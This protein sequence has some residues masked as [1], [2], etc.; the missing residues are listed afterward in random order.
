MFERLHHHLKGQSFRI[1]EMAEFAPGVI[2]VH[3]NYG[4][5]GGEFDV[6]INA[7]AIGPTQPEIWDQEDG[8]VPPGLKETGLGIL[9]GVAFGRRPKSIQEFF[10]V[11]PQFL[12]GKTAPIGWYKEPKP[13]EVPTT[14]R[15]RPPQA[16]SC[17]GRAWVLSDPRSR[18]SNIK[19]VF[20]QCER[21]EN[22]KNPTIYGWIFFVKY[23]I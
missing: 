2:A 14:S 1:R 10:Q 4:D 12:T 22:L 18:C 7:D 21:F 20:G 15:P 8:L 9:Q 3:D 5:Q 17:R 16:V 23:L 19:L 6:Y 11:A 13:L